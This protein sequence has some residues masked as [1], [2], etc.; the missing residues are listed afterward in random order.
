VSGLDA[1]AEVAAASPVPIA[2]DESARLPGAL[3]R[4]QADSVCLKIAGCGGISGVI[5]A[6]SR[7][8]ATGYNVYLA[9]T[10][11][12]PLGIAAALHAAAIVTPDRPSGLATLG[13]FDGRPDPLPP[14]DGRMTAPTGPGLGIEPGAWY[15]SR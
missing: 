11:D 1:L 3:H 2:L 15:A 8:R 13:L 9:S 14:V 4:R 5:D 10:L 12:G 6:V 7:A